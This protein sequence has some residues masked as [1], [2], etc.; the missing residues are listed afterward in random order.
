MSKAYEA[1]LDRLTELNDQ[2][3]A[4]LQNRI[5]AHLSQ[6]DALVNG[7]TAT[8]TLPKRPKFTTIEELLKN[9]P[10]PLTSEEVEENLKLL[11]RIDKEAKKFGRHQGE[12]FDAVKLVREGRD[13]HELC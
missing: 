5:A 11:E 10:P 7:T 3:L 8:K 9:P 1:I 2:E 12:E 6:K 4:D 13:R